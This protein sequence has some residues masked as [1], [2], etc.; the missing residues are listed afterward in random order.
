MIFNV[1]TYTYNHLICLEK[2]INMYLRLIILY[3]QHNFLALNTYLSSFS[4]KSDAKIYIE[5]WP[6]RCWDR[7]VSV[8][9]TKPSGFKPINPFPPPDT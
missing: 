1:K 5:D 2:N 6:I 9:S 3:T 7:A 4:K 8:P